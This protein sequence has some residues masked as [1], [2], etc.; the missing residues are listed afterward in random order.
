MRIIAGTGPQDL[1]AE[2]QRFDYPPPG[3]ASRP[4]P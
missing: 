2:L 4:A 3:P 1:T